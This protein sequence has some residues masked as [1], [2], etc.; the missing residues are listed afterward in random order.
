[1][2]DQP[3]PSSVE[4]IISSTLYPTSFPKAFSKQLILFRRQMHIACICLS[5]QIGF[6][7]FHLPDLPA[8]IIHHFP[9]LTQQAENHKRGISL[10]PISRTISIDSHYPLFLPVLLLQLVATTVYL[11]RF[12]QGRIYC[13]LSSSTIKSRTGCISPLPTPRTESA[14]YPPLPS[15]RPG[16]TVYPPL[17]FSPRQSLTPPYISFYSQRD[18]V[19]QY[20][21]HSFLKRKP[22]V[23]TITINCD[24]ESVSSRKCKEGGIPTTSTMPYDK[25]KKPV[26]VPSVGDFEG[27][28]ISS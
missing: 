27:S 5:N 20:I 25:G 24:T 1:V 3:L 13:I 26:F 7:R 16:S 4:S 6:L 19:L 17:H 15:S 21:H 22:S 28:D 8:P 9:H 12:L 23:L 18:L 14:T 2:F 11:A 10:L